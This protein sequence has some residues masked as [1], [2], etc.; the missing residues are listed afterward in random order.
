MA[1]IDGPCNSR[2]LVVNPYYRC[3]PKMNVFGVH[4]AVTRPGD[5]NGML[6]SVGSD[7]KDP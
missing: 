6:N 3:C 4:N 5:A 2:N 7:A 1:N